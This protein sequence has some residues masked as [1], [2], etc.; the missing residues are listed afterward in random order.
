MWPVY[1]S[2]EGGD[3]TTQTNGWREWEWEGSEP[4]NKRMGRFISIVT[5]NKRYNMTFE[6]TPPL[7]MELQFQRRKLTEGEPNNFI[8]VM[9]TYPL[10]NSIRIMNGANVIA[11]ISLLDNNSEPPL[12]TTLCGSNKYFFKNSTIHY[13]V[14]G[15]LGCRVRVTLTTSLQLTARFSMSVDDF[16]TANG[17]TNFI[18]RLCALLGITDTSRVKVVG[19][20]SGSTIVEAVIEEPIIPEEDSTTSDPVTL[21]AEMAAIQ[22]SLTALEDS[23]SLSTG[24]AASG[25]TGFTDLST[26]LHTNLSDEEEPQLQKNKIAMI[27]GIIIGASVLIAM[28]VLGSMYC[29]RRRAK[30][31][32]LPAMSVTEARADKDGDFV[33]SSMQNFEK[34]SKL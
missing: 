16:F 4:M 21:A 34:S 26:T 27:A 17:K 8:V 24:F 11:P 10:P 3:W 5:L 29:V 28:V 14:T 1:L 31:G 22:T 6:S 15:Q 18:D 30:V 33:E 12:D 13:V 25:L 19:V 32:E 23:G 9:L 7:D 2:Y 20:Y